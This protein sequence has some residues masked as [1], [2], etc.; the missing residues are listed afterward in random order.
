MK[1]VAMTA[2]LL[3]G[4]FI[5]GLSTAA[6]LVAKVPEAQLE[7]RLFDDRPCKLNSSPVFKGAEVTYQGRRLEACWAMTPNGI[8]VG[9][10]DGETAII[11]PSKFVKDK[12][13]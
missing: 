11:D 12:E 9:D 5:S 8:F 7:I 2:A 10:E 1:P 13:A 6:S 4:F 3:V